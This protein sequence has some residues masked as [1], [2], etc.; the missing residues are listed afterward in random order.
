MSSPGADLF[1]VCKQCGSQVSPYITECPYCGHRLRRRAPKL[2]RE[3]DK[4][5]TRHAHVPSSLGRLRAGEIPGIKT[6]SPPYVT[7]AAVVAT[8]GVWIAWRG[9]FVNFFNLVIVGPLHGD[10]WR[11]V[12]VQFAYASGFYQFTT[13]VAIA[14]FGWLLERRHGSL[15]VLALFFGCGVGGAL[16]E[17][18]VYPEPLMTGGNAVAL[19]LLG[20]WAVPDLLSLR[21]RSYYDGDLL[22]ALAFAAALLGM[23]LARTEASW[24]AG[25]TGGA[26]GLAVGAGINR[27]HHR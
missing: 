11:L 10:A 1:V 9:G 3:G 8:C 22:G 21:S 23:S 25:V 14:L 15:F 20:A 6:D 19:G 4:A 16:V 2:P 13:L 18:A 27:V 26:I 12:T 24:L 17:L 5:H 7:A